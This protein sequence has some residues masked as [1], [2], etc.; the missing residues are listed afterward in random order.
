[1]SRFLSYMTQLHSS[2]QIKCGSM[3]FLTD[4][5]TKTKIIVESSY[6]FD[7][8]LAPQCIARNA[9]RAQALLDKTTF[10]HQVYL[11]VSHL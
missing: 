1:M 5:K 9:S 4:V 7:T 11:I 3:K 10:I 6:G 2:F 8:S